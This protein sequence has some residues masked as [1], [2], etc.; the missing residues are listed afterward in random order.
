MVVQRGIKVPVWGWAEAGTKI[1]VKLGEQSAEATAD[2]KGAW[3]AE[4][5][6]ME[7]GGPFELTV[8]GKETKT[9]KNVMVGD[10]WVCSGQSN[11][12]WGLW[13]IKNS[14]EEIAAAK[15]PNIRLFAVQKTI[16][17]TPKDD[18][19]TGGWVECGP[20]TVTG[21]SAVGY[22]FG[23]HLHEQL[24]VPIGLIHTS[25]GGTVAEAWT[26]R[27]ALAK[28]EDFK[29]VMESIEKAEANLPELQKE[30]DAKLAEWKKAVE[31][32]DPG[33]KDAEK[34]WFKP[35]TDAAAWKPLD[36][37]SHWEKGGLPDFDGVVWF[38][39]EVEIPEAWA[40]KELTLSLGPIDDADITWFN[41]TQVGAT[42]GWN[43]A[44]KYK[45]PGDLVKAGKN[46]LA[47]RVLDTGGPGG[48]YGKPEQLTLVP[49]GMADAKPVSLAGAWSFN[50]GMSLQEIPARP[51][52]PASINNQ[53]SPTALYNGMLAPVI[54]YGIKGAIWYQGESNAGRAFQYRTLFPAMIQDWR[55]RWGEGDF[56]FFFV[57]LA[58][59]MAAK[60]EPG[61]SAWAELR[62]AQRMTLS[63]PNTGMATIIDIGEAGDIH[64]KNKQDVGLRLAL[65]ARGVAYG[66]KLVYSGP[67]YKSMAVEEGKI[68]LTFDHVGGGL[69]AKGGEPLKSF[70]I[71]G[72]D[73]VFV[74]ADAKIDG[75]TVVVS[76]AKVEKPV[77]VRY[78][79]ADNPEG[80]NL[81]NK[82][83]LP[84]SPFRTDDWPGVTVKNK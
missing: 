21:F 12:E 31:A 36:L 55:G 22:F 82:D 61:E 75:E 7:A 68:R 74:W 10:V 45:V 73:K 18:P 57:Q 35:E 17:A 77:A 47:V 50:P 54:P 33:T 84:A 52:P 19:A 9:L 43:V 39:R 42:D 48:L 11:M 16:S 53:N 71:A 38:R 64:P 69:E 41:G 78:A 5:P 76:S 65:A 81:Y 70:A 83:G 1:T 26:S 37:P 24:K 72:E 63:L 34:A 25:W 3:K 46:T 60:P 44:R 62:E 58:N 20:G 27:E 79:W 6:A 56:P 59:F 67:S 40:S 4:L 29:P 13:G 28:L 32:A 2:E 15:F 51:L 80:C 30:Y 14:K 49:A 8:T 66:E 23:R